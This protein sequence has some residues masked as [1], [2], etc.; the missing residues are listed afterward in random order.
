MKLAG[1]WQE[2]L[3]PP[4]DGGIGGNEFF[5]EH[6]ARILAR[7]AL[8]AVVDERHFSMRRCVCLLGR[9]PIVELPAAFDVRGLVLIEN[10]LHIAIR[11]RLD[12][13]VNV[14]RKPVLLHGGYG[15]GWEGIVRE[16]VS[17]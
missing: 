16:A 11:G 4:A 10:G 14:F 17:A 5:T 1:N 13:N 2:I 8:S 7:H 3:C 9:K 6:V 15:S 12:E